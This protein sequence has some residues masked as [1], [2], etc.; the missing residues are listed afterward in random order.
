MGTLG[1]QEMIIIFVLA[2]L[3]F[4]PKKLPELG[5]TAAKALAEFRKAS[6][7]LKASLEREVNS[8][9]RESESLKSEVSKH[10]QDPVYNY[11]EDPSYYDS[12]AYGSETYDSTATSTNTVSASAT[13]GAEQTTAGTNALPAPDAEGKKDVAAAVALQNAPEGTV[14]H[15]A[16]GEPQKAAS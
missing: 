5:R 7:D 8:L 9:E 2:L 12:G 13:Q 14:P 16:N 6:A 3:V 1:T 15:T 4:G 10:L 11:H